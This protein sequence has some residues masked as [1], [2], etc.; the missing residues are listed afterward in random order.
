MVIVESPS[1]VLCLVADVPSWISDL[2]VL[3]TWDEHLK[4]EICLVVTTIIR[5]LNYSVS[6]C[7]FV[8]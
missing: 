4:L 3:R 8:L 2:I 1:A 6:C 5:L 7:V